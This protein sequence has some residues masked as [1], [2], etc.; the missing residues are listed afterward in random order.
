L[1][2]GAVLITVAVGAT[3][4]VVLRFSGPE[5]PEF[6]AGRAFS[7]LET[8][9]SFGPR[10]PGSRAHEEALAF[11]TDRLSELADQVTFQPV[12]IPDV[13]GDT[14]RGTNLI[15]S[16]NLQPERN[17]RIMLGAHWDSRPFADQDP[18]PDNRNRP[19]P[20]ANDGASGTAM[21]LEMA[22]M[23]H[24]YPP[25]IGVD[26][27]LFD[28]EDA[29]VDT[30]VPFAAGSEQFAAQNGHYRPTF[31]IIVDMICDRDLR[32]PREGNSQQAARRIV[33]LVWEAA[34]QENAA[35]FLDEITAGVN[36]DHLPFLRRGIPVIDIIQS[37]FPDYWHT[38]EDTI[39]KCS[40]ASLDQV[41]RV[42]NRVVYTY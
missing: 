25:K 32:L 38:V 24:E 10:V 3:L 42:V 7:D 15:A 36:D 26:L 22:R 5:I 16:F 39:D 40:V 1:I 4:L 2:A 14:L 41:G 35:A 23:L 20:G 6:D 17:V 9:V 12:S 19:V 37:P 29:G 30:T 28:L 34:D 33:D 11:L 18:N 8:I 13:N 31:G 27:L 21:L